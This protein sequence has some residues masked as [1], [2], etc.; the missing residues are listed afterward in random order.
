MEVQV[1]AHNSPGYWQTIDLRRRILR[2]PLGLD[3]TDDQLAAESS[4]IHIAAFDGDRLTGCLVLTPVDSDTIKMRQ[5]AV[6]PD[7]QGQ[8]IGAQMVRLSESVAA[9]RGFNEMILHARDT[10]VPFYL[11]LGYELFGEPFEEVTIPHRKMRKALG[12]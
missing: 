1:V 10:A 5:V 2:W 3:F 6:E 4:D 9:E 8:G 12:P 7:L 11:R